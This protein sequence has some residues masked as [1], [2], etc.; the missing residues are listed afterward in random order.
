MMYLRNRFICTRSSSMSD[1]ILDY[2]RRRHLSKEYIDRKCVVASDAIIVPIY[3]LD[4][5]SW[6][7]ERYITPKNWVKSR[8][9]PWSKWFRFLD[10]R[11]KE[12]DILIVEWEIDFLSILPFATEYNVM[13]IKWI[14]N[15]P[16]AIMEIETLKKVYDVYILVDNDEP[17]DISIKRIPY[18]ELHLYDVRDALNWC[19]DVNEAICKWKLN[20][21]AIP[22]R[23]VKLKPVEKKINRNW[24]IDT[25]EKINEIPAID[26]L[27]TLFPQYRRRGAESITEDWK[28]THGYKYSK[29][30]N[31]ITDFSWKWRPSWT[32]YM[33][34]KE[35]FGDSHTTF[36]YFQW[37]L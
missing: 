22:R 34:A 8:T 33:I 3:S 16:H 29:W 26:I 5:V 4:G 13:W 7:Q 32:T 36:L 24:S 9:Q 15:L 17:A 25:V 30:M 28:E 23:I 12:K 11:D 2:I 14:G 35:K 6:H 10:K 18:T 1:P 37:K 21:K 19:K 31:I 20:M 27:E